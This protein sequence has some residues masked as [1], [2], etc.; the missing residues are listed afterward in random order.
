M[1]SGQELSILCQS[2]N[3]ASPCACPQPAWHPVA[4]KCACY[5]LSHAERLSPIG[6]VTD[7]HMRGQFTAG[8]SGAASPACWGGRQ[9]VDA[10][11]PTNGHPGPSSVSERGS[12]EGLLQ[13]TATLRAGASGVV[14]P[15]AVSQ[16]DRGPGGAEE[17]KLGGT[18]GAL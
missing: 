13:L 17:T 16:S 7:R 9:R 6:A 11:S 15:A 4:L 12:R 3:S 14:C 1:D 18:R 10:L 8:L 2:P 5:S